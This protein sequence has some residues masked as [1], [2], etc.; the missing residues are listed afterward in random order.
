MAMASLDVVRSTGIDLTI[1]IQNDEQLGSEVK[2]L[3][4]YGLP[5]DIVRQQLPDIPA[6]ARAFGGT[7]YVVRTE[8][9]I[10]SLD[11]GQEP[12]LRII[13][14]RLDPEV[15]GRAAFG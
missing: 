13:D 6:L 8:E 14:V 1:V 4:E 9:D 3:R 12:G 11:L 5:L 2:Y 7:G 15:N 10:R